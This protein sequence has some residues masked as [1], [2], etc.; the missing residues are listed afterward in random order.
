[1]RFVLAAVLGLVVSSCT[2]SDSP[3][4]PVSPVPPGVDA[5][6]L[7]APTSA[8]S[9]GEDYFQIVH[10]AEGAI[11][12][13][14]QPITIILDQELQ[15]GPVQGLGVLDAS[16]NG[17]HWRTVSEFAWSRQETRIRFT[18]IL[19]VP[20]TFQLRVRVYEDGS[21]I[22][23]IESPVVTVEGREAPP[24]FEDIAPGVRG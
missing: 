3:V 4:S 22:P 5:P 13:V 1:M 20:N 12:W 2:P 15:G 16:V 10:P 19:P 9:Q 23:W 11:V 17:T 18:A 21:E 7:A 24:T 8:H 14:D 6:W